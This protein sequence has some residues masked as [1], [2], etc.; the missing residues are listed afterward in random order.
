MEILNTGPGR[1]GYVKAEDGS[2]IA[3]AH[4]YRWF[5]SEDATRRKGQFSVRASLP[6]P[7][8]PFAIMSW[9]SRE[10]AEEALAKLI[11][12]VER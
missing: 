2:Y 12:A 4:V 1:A 3:I 10:K 8:Q 6:G 11:M 7:Q 5:I 9:D